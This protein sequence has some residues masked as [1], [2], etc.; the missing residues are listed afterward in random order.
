MSSEPGGP[1]SGP[2]G[3]HRQPQAMFT[4]GATL[5]VDGGWVFRS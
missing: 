5:P 1:L 3:V 4:T 2:S